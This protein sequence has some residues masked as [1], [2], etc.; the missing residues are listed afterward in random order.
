L[1]GACDTFKLSHQWGSPQRA[2]LNDTLA[3]FT[4]VSNTEITAKVPTGAISGT[5]SVMTPTGTLNSNPAFR[6]TK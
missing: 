1:N 5:V 4:V 6:V 2:S 3:T